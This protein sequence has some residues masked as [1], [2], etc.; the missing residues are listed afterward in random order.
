MA[1]KD[2][3]P[4][5]LYN[6]LTKSKE[7]FK[8]IH[9]DHVGM[10]VCGPTVYSNVHLGNV[11]TFMC[12]DVIYRYLM[13]L[14]YK[15][16]YV[17]NITDV[18][19]LENDADEGEDK[20]A[21]KARL[22][23]L[24][25]MEIVQQYTNDFHQVLEQFNFLPP[26]I[27]PSATGHIMEQIEMVEDLLKKG[28]AYEV[29]GSVYFDVSKY[30][31]EHH[32]G[33]LSGRNIEDLME[34]GRMLDSQD[35][36][37]NKIDFAIWKKASP[38]H[39][40]RWNSPW[41]EGFPG[42]HLECTVMSTKYLG[43]TFD[44]HGGGMDL[45]F[46]HHECEIAQSVGAKGAE[47]VKYW[48]HSNMLTVNGQKMSKSLGN[49]FL[50]HELF[51]GNHKVLDRGY[52]PMVVRFFMLQSHYSSTL[53]FSNEA[54]SAAE[55]G[56]KRLMEGLKISKSLTYNAGTVN[57]EIEDK[58]KDTIAALFQNMGEDFNTAKALAVLFEI[59][60]MVNNLKSGNLKSGDLSEETFN[61]LIT[62]Y[63]GMIQDVLGLKE[64]LEADSDLVGGVID[65]L[66]KVR[67][68]AK[69]AK[70]YAMSDKIRDD[71]KAIGVTLKDG[72]DGTEYSID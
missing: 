37:R 22:E 44:I 21:K 52:S 72:K 45:V 41:G 1:L 16:R 57:P 71:L 58:A 39:I 42:W 48:L 17:R 33:K 23:E 32:Y 7:E 46:P 55:K 18:G 15:V 34:S 50:P 12:F 67:N 26:S 51:T 70:N 63:Q 54:L 19:H 13:Y 20:I 36:K 3:Y 53:D 40:M 9:D 38:A 61:E 69:A 28:L 47:P 4:I 29:N 66:I 6:T 62:H 30:D 60:S 25:P 43:E 59:T 68:D 2:K 24:E 8:P 11:R 64:E 5:T 14:G 65:V 10:Y 31:K 27:E 35:E 56:Y 49:S